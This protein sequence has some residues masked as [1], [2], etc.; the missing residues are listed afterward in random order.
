MAHDHGNGN[1][2][3]RTV[4]QKAYYLDGYYNIIK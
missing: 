1:E 2:S 3:K 4:M